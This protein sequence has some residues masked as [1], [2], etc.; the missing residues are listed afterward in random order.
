MRIY[1][2]QNY[3]NLRFTAGNPNISANWRISY[4]PQNEDK[5]QNQS[6][7]P[8]WVRKSVLFG[9]IGLAVANDPATKEFFKP[10]SIKQQE[11]VQKKYFNDVAKIGNTT[12]SYHLNRLADV[13]K[14]IIK[15]NS[16]PGNYSITLNLDNHQ[17]IDLSIDIPVKEENVLSGSFKFDNK[18]RTSFKAFFNPK[19]KEEFIVELR[20]TNPEKYIF[21]RNENGEL[22]QKINNKKVI[23]NKENVQRYQDELQELQES[24]N[25]EFFTNKNDLWRKLNLILL[26]LLTLNEWGHDLQKRDEEKIRNEKMRDEK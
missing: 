15:S 5:P 10:E 23:L 1:S 18:R 9:L 2:I 14:P 11:I 4:E 26:F 16:I 22:Y 24:E 20:N 13:D 3:N 17:K 6:R 8:E 25:F 7:I 21:G 19:N 12:T